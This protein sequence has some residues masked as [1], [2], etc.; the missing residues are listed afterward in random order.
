MEIVKRKPGRPRI[1]VD[2]HKRSV[3]FPAG[4]YD[5]LEVLAREKRY[6]TVNELLVSVVR[7][8]VE[9]QKERQPA[10]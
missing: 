6:S 9:K 2:A 3:T 4:L 5:D 10:T 7:D 1:L 8:F